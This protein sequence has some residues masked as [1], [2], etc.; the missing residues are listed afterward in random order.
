MSLS[1]LE[2]LEKLDIYIVTNGLNIDV[3]WLRAVYAK[4]PPNP[5]SHYHTDTEFHHVKHGAFVVHFEDES[6][7]V[8]EGQTIAIGRNVSHRLEN[9]FETPYFCYSI[10]AKILL[11]DKDDRESA[12]IFNSLD[13]KKHLLIP[14][15]FGI[16]ELFDRCLNESE[17]R[18]SGFITMINSA[19]VQILTMLA[20]EINENPSA[21]YSVKEKFNVYDRLGN[22][23]IKAID[24]SDITDLSVQNIAESMCMSAK[25]VQRIAKLQFGVTLKRLIMQR[26]VEYAKELL[27]DP[28]VSIPEV[29]ERLGFTNEYYFN[30][31]F[32]QMEGLPPGRY[33]RSLKSANKNEV[34]L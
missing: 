6:V 21:D 16:G 15:D 8:R 10:K 7:T 26:K 18:K 1:K 13:V 28:L 31:F 34:K 24:G 12:F 25:Q 19:I 14:H 30:R 4:S 23:L 9:P 27:K 20:R 2:Q 17:N 3:E 29:S 22:E 11:T 33:R 5:K 32:K